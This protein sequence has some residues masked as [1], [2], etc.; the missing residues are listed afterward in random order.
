MTSPGPPP[1]AAEIKERVDDALHGLELEPGESADILSFA[2]TEVPHLQTP[3]RSFLVLGS[4]R[5]P[6]ERRLRFVENELNRGVGTYAFT[7]GDIRQLD[8]ARL[9]A[10]RI[11]FYIIAPYVD[12]IVGVY[13]QDAGGEVTELGKISETPFFEKSRV[14]PRDY[15]WM[16]DRQLETEEDVHAAAVQ[17]GLTDELTKNEITEEL[18]T[19]V[20][21]A[22]L[23][24][25]DTSIDDVTEIVAERREDGPDVSTYSWVQ[26]NEFRLFEL[27]GSCFPWSDSDDLRTNV[28][29]IR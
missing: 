25:I 22:Q 26:V 4:F 2:N 5:P 7:L 29:R 16:T 17:I 27:H 21:N 23:N 14:L 8:L 1:N 18:E 3:E 20:E 13:E 10:F 28:R 12:E 6:Y 11:R 19:L 24:G 9:P 15:A